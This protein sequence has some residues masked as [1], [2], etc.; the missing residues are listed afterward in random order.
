M[1]VNESEASLETQGAEAELALLEVEPGVAVLFGEAAPEGWE[2]EPFGLGDRSNREIIDA[3]SNAVGAAN[4][5]AQ[6]LGGLV[7]AQGLVR[8]SPET[9]RNLKTMQT[10]VEG[11]Y[12][13]GVLKQGGKFAAHILG[14]SRGRPGSICSGEP[15]PFARASDDQ[16][17]AH[18]DLQQGR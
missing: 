15:G 11:N 8:L 18:R 17:S 5:V 16:C 10:M 13:L 4:A 14:A 3:L 6:G 9:I 1:G 7:S 12:N 2:V